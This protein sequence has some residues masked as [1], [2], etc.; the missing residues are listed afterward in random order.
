MKVIIAFLLFYVLHNEG[1]SSFS[2][3][4]GNHNELPA[5][6]AWIKSETGIWLCDNNSWYKFDKSSLEA[7][8]TNT[9]KV[10]YNKKKWVIVDNAVWQDKNGKW[11]FISNNRL[12]CTSDN[13]HWI[14]VPNRTWLGIDN[15]WRRFDAN[16][17]LWEVKP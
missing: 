8:L 2:A 15:V 14:E 10:S 5:E 16:W 13:K 7:K 1:I 4:L 9:I 11:Y 6:T 12:L 17:E 3:T